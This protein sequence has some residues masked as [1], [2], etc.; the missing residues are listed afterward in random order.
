[1]YEKLNETKPL[2]PKNFRPAENGMIG[3]TSKFKKQIM[4]FDDG[5]KV[6]YYPSVSC[7]DC[8]NISVGPFN[9]GRKPYL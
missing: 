1:M 4:S 6:P 5:D 2:S 3:L 7:L 9:Y 8:K